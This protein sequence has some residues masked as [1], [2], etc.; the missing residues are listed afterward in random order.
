M[1]PHIDAMLAEAYY[2]LGI[3]SVKDIDSRIRKARAYLTAVRERYIEVAESDV[4]E[5][6]ITTNHGVI[7]RQIP[8]AYACTAKKTG[9]R[10]GREVCVF[11]LIVSNTKARYMCAHY[12]S[13]LRDDPM[14]IVYNFP[15]NY[16][17]RLEDI[18]PAMRVTDPQ[19]ILP[20]TTD[21]QWNAYCMVFNAMEK[22]CRHL[23]INSIPHKTEQ[24]M[25]SLDSIE[26]E[27]LTVAGENLSGKLLPLAQQESLWE[28]LRE[29]HKYSTRKDLYLLVQEEHCQYILK[30]HHI[31]QYFHKVILDDTPG[32]CIYEPT[33]NKQETVYTFTTLDALPPQ[34]Y[35]LYY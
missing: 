23:P 1:T 27:D 28:E 20:E 24:A 6:M 34:M 31:Y 8:L 2:R 16:F 25:F 17:A 3:H 7:C 26:P 22:Y 4:A 5:Y 19:K 11:S 21:A 29:D 15:V 35:A 33:E 13:Q 32:G 30:T 10:L 12:R 18:T 14:D 9:S